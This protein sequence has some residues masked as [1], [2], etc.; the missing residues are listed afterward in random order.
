MNT[1]LSS[2]SRRTQSV[3]IRHICPTGFSIRRHKSIETRM[4]RQQTRLYTQAG[5]W[6]LASTA[7]SKLSTLAMVKRINCRRMKQ[8]PPSRSA[9]ILL[10]PTVSGSTYYR[11][12]DILLTCCNLCS[13]HHRVPHSYLSLEH[14]H[15]WRILLL[16][17]EREAAQTLGAQN[18]IGTIL[19]L[20]KTEQHVFP[21]KRSHQ[22][23]FFYAFFVFDFKAS[24]EQTDRQTDGQE[25]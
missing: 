7:Q 15:Q 12:E 17:V 9:Q 4:S 14:S 25:A 5:V 10:Q 6:S 21:T 24:R 11:P 2:R 20:R 22:F 8:N 18:L 1:S 3:R 23:W 19:I 16:G 13:S